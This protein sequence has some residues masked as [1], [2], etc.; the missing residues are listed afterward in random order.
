MEL[1]S[2]VVFFYYE[3][4]INPKVIVVFIKKSQTKKPKYFSTTSYG[5]MPYT[6][7]ILLVNESLKIQEYDYMRFFIKRTYD[8]LL[9]LWA[10]HDTEDTLG[11]I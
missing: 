3:I 11:E 7:M 9:Y 1:Q 5:F 8:V 2:K 4:S 6:D 10:Q